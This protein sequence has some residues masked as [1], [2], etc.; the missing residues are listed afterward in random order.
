MRL[1]YLSILLVA[2]GRSTNHTQTNSMNIN[3]IWHRQYRFGRG[4]GKEIDGGLEELA[5]RWWLLCACECV[6]GE[7]SP[8][9]QE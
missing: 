5:E 6:R 8:C 1:N 7:D 3:E 4:A 9:G 2:R